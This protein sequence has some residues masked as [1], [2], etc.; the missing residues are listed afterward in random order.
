MFP[1]HEW[2]AAYGVIIVFAVI[3]LESAGVPLPGESALVTAAIYAGTT[4][5]MDIYTLVA[6]AAV[7]AILGDN[8]GYWVGRRF[9]FNL[10][11]RYGHYLH[12]P[13]ARLKMG[14][15]LFLRQGGKIVFFGRFV[16]FLRTFAAVLAG[17]N[18]YEW[19]RFLLFNALGAIGWAMV[20]GVGGYLLGRSIETVTRPLAIGGIVAAII[21]L[22]AGLLL[23]RRYE[24]R[25]TAEAEIALP[26][27][28]AERG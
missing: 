20:F 19:R 3:M 1:L 15:Y 16:A 14:Q 5:R 17:V 21:G 22:V 24:E 6:S 8:I 26:G 7:A 11:L 23:F 28:L 12:L 9:G 4:Q 25:W 18:L 27:P 13:Q 10:L 2:I